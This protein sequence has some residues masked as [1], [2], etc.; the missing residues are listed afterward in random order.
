MDKDD[1]MVGVQAD[2]LTLCS[3][4]N[5]VPGQWP[6]LFFR[7]RGMKAH[8]PVNYLFHIMRHAEGKHF[9]FKA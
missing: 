6:R 1:F 5:F 7:C 4:A 3:R 9:F 2:K 8:P